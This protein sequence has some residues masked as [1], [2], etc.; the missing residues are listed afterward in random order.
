MAVVA[1]AV[2]AAGLALG[3]QCAAEVMADSTAVVMRF[4]P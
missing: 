2:V 1:G 3:E 4:R